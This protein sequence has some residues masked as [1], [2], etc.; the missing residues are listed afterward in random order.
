MSDRNREYDP[1]ALNRPPSTMRD[2]GEF[3]VEI[4]TVLLALWA[5]LH[6]LMMTYVAVLLILSRSKELSTHPIAVGFGLVVTAVVGLLLVRT[7]RRSW[8]QGRKIFVRLLACLGLLWFLSEPF[9][10]HNFS[11]PQIPDPI[12]GNK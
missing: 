8:T 4:I 10:L 6:V 2:L 1:K 7:A 3:F 9:H 11:E 5:S 12:S